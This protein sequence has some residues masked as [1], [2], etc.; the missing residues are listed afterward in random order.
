MNS[1][2]LVSTD[3]GRVRGKYSEGTH[4]FLGIPYAESTAG[5][6]RF[7][8]PVRKKPWPDMRAAYEKGPCCPQNNYELPAWQD[9]GLQS[10]DCLV[11]NI[12]T[13][14]IDAAANLPVMLWIHGGAYTTGSAG[15]AL[16]DGTSLAASEE[17]V[18][19]SIN[20]RIN[21]F[22]Y[23]YLGVIDP[24]Y[25]E[26]ANLGQQDIVLALEWV[27][28]N[29]AR[30]GGNSANVT[31]F[32]ESGGGSKIYALTGMP[33]A[34]GLF[35]KVII[36]SGWLLNVLTPDEAT[37]RA[38]MLLRELGVGRHALGALRTCPTETMRASEAIISK[39]HGYGVFFPVADG[40]ILTVDPWNSKSTRARMSLPMLIGVTADEAAYFVPA[41][42]Y[43]KPLADDA[44]LILA[45]ETASAPI[46]PTREE[47][48][49]LVEDYRSMN[50]SEMTRLQLCI[51]IASDLLF[52]GHTTLLAE[53]HAKHSP[54]FMYRFDWRFP[55]WGGQ[56][57]PHG[58]EIPFIFDTLDYP[59]PAWDLDDSPTRRACA[60]P[61]SERYKLSAVMRATWA[62]FARTGNPSH[63]ELPF[64]PPYTPS[65]RATMILDAVSRV[66]YDPDRARRLSSTRAAV[67]SRKVNV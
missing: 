10:E 49:A 27:R 60:D 26:S 45:I 54:V 59:Q 46:S 14:T 40:R 15:V 67:P 42:L 21:L 44:A 8:P 65:R 11:L 62:T 31:L 2:V 48:R 16:Y 58:A 36:Q 1:E 12:W 13:P 30:F 29:I 66:M 19:V 9:A 33:S 24:R 34:S 57:S 22:G 63:S 51:E 61:N 20:H 64:W 25:A 3:S 56:Y 17:V 37:Q 38:E 28:D 53:R 5:P 52:V 50:S 41:E 4:S 35:H 55:C 23:L 6:R 43:T 7:T 39:R 18:V 47:I 32:G